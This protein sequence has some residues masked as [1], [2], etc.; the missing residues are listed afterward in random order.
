MKEVEGNKVMYTVLELGGMDLFDYF[1]KAIRVGRCLAKEKAN[2]DFLV[3]VFRGAAQ[4]LEQFHKCGG[5]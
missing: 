4:A 3:K 5:Y 2:E 1:D